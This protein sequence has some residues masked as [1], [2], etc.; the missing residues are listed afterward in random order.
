M[1]FDSVPTMAAARSRPAGSGRSAPPA[2]PAPIL[3]DVPTIAEA[4][5]PDYEA[6][7]WI[8]VMA[9][10]GTP[11]P[12]VDVLNREINKILRASRHQESGGAR[13]RTIVDAARTSSAPICS[14]RSST[15]QRS[16]S[17]ESA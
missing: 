6:T 13:A 10:A 15:G 16:S 4:G 7:I 11:Q 3:P 5:V 14:P 1:M 12:I 2:R 8:G 9:P 17:D